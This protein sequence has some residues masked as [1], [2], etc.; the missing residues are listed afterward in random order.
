MVIVK[1]L[2]FLNNQKK[3]VGMNVKKLMNVTLA[4]MLGLLVT[5][6]NAQV[7]TDAGNQDEEPGIKFESKT[8]DFGKI[9]HG[10]NASTNFKFTN[11]GDAPLTLKD[12]RPSCGCTAPKWPKKPI[13][14]GE[15]ATIKA[16]YDGS[17]KG[18]F[19]KSIT[20]KTNVKDNS[21]IVLSIKGRVN[22]KN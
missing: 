6:L 12:V 15:S 18:R 22:T 4:L 1:C 8:H 14:P 17:G 2:L 20:V 11:T 5:P 19:Q 13:M 9:P 3:V 7:T 21:R 16:V 10:Q